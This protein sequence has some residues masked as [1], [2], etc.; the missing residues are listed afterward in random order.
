MTRRLTLALMLASLTGGALVQGIVQ[1]TLIGA[2]Q[3]RLTAQSSELTSGD[4]VW[5]VSGPCGTGF[6]ELSSMNGRTPIGTTTANGNLG[7][8]GGSDTITPAGTNAALTFTGTAWSAPAVS[9]P[10]GV[11][12]HTGTTA[13]FTGNASSCVVNHN[14]NLATGTGTTGN[15][16]QVIGTVD[17]SSGGTGGTPTQT[18]LGTLSGNPTANGAATCTPAG[19]VSITAQGTIAWPAGVP[20]IASYTP[21]GTIN[22]P[23]FTGTQFDNRSAFTRGIF[24]QKN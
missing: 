20:T 13:S 4:I 24:C 16:S 1:L 9:W 23:T 12:T 19:S 17:T 8:T 3:P 11:P 22:T 18:A 2:G 7:T 14:H 10:A 21:A 5:R 6:T 15:F